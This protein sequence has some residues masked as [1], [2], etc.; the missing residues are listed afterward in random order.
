MQEKIIEIVL[1]TTKNMEPFLT[2]SE[3]YWIASILVLS[4]TLIRVVYKYDKELLFRRIKTASIIA[5]ILVIGFFM[6]NYFEL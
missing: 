2:K 3:I 6:I 1:K 4:V 5:F